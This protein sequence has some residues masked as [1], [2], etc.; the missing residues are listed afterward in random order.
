MP[1][2]LEKK[3]RKEEKE[4]PRAA[5]QGVQGGSEEADGDELRRQRH[6]WDQSGGK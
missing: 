2:P 3:K 5:I 1:F 6:R 4:C